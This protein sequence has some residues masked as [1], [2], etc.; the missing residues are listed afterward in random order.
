M[1]HPVLSEELYFREQQGGAIFL[2]LLSHFL[3]LLSLQWGQSCRSY[4]SDAAVCILD[5]YLGDN[6]RHSSSASGIGSG[7]LRK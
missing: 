7:H 6:D 1:F 4:S 2:T 3:L 5:P